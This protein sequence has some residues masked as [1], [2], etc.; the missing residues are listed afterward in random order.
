VR[1]ARGDIL[2]NFGHISNG[3]S[4]DPS[5]VAA[6]IASMPGCKLTVRRSRR[7]PGMWTASY[8]APRIGPVAYELVARIESIN[9]GQWLDAFG[10][11]HAYDSDWTS[12]LDGS[13]MTVAEGYAWRSPA[14]RGR[15]EGR[16]RKLPRLLSFNPLN[17]PMALGTRRGA[18]DP[19]SRRPAF[20]P[21]ARLDGRR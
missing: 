10:T 2:D 20:I 12:T 7:R 13:W 9:N 5:E 18:H 19:R 11:I 6:L 14:Q 16:Q 1:P 8:T 15:R 21:T 4:A 17:E 3:S